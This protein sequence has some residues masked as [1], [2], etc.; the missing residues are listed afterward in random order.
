[1]SIVLRMF[2]KNIIWKRLARRSCTEVGRLDD[3]CGIFTKIVPG[4]G[5]MEGDVSA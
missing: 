5:K 1:M 3:I 2:V 4:N